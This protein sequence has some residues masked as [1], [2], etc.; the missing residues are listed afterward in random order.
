MIGENKKNSFIRRLPRVDDVFLQISL[1]SYVLHVSPK[2]FRPEYNNWWG[3]RL[4]IPTMKIPRVQIPITSFTQS[5]RNLISKTH[6]C[7][8]LL[9]PSRSFG[10]FEHGME[11]RFLKRGRSRVLSHIMDQ[12]G[13]SG[14]EGGGVVFRTGSYR[15][16]TSSSCR[17][18][19]C[20]WICF[21]SSP[22][23]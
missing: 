12:W 5:F 20:Q 22:S 7:D 14:V 4:D 23:V 15:Q 17:F 19:V 11:F 6:Y 10:S 1:F 16:S 8:G 21:Q 9:F 3:E 13:R 18:S 2:I